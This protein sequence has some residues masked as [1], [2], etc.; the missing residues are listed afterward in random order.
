MEKND[1][2]LESN[3]KLE[4]VLLLEKIY[5]Y[6]PQNRT[7]S[8][9]IRD[10]LNFIYDLGLMQKKEKDMLI[11]HFEEVVKRKMDIS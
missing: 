10:Q 6:A 8:S 11:S 9:S 4:V 2:N 3:V 5:D 7:F 1:L